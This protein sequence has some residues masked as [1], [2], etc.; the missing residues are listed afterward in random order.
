MSS[1]YLDHQLVRT[2][3][4]AFLGRVI[5]RSALLSEESFRFLGWVGRMCVGGRGL[6]LNSLGADEVFQGVLLSLA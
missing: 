4:V 1:Y 6:S 2:E 3:A 5:N